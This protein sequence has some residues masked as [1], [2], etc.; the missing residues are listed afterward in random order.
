LQKLMWR[1]YGAMGTFA[2][3]IYFIARYVH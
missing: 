1:L 3:G 2:A